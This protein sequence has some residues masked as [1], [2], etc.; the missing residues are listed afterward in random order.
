[1]IQGSREN[2]KIDYFAFKYRRTENAE[3]RNHNKTYTNFEK[4]YDRYLI[5]EI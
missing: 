4:E 3:I 5:G 2:P 1:L